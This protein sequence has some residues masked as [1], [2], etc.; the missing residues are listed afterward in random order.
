MAAITPT[1]KT[2]TEFA[3]DYKVAV[4]K[5]T[6]TTSTN[7]TV[8]ISEMGTIVG[9]TAT[10]AAATTADCAQLSITGISTNVMT[11][12]AMKAAGAICTQTPIAFYITAI[13]Y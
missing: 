4:V 10:P 2:V 1:T 3:G 7:D 8:T 5:I 9:A 13:G 6:A 12:Q 11:V